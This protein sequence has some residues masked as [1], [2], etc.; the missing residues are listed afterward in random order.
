MIDTNDCEMKKIELQPRG[1]DC[2][3]YSLNEPK[4]IRIECSQC[5]NESVRPITVTYASSH[6]E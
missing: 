2:Q 6:I 3:T 5:N 4:C 1:S